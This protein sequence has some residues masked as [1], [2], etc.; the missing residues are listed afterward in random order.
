MAGV[1]AQDL[2]MVDVYSC[3]PV[4]VQIASRELK[5]DTTRP[6]TVTGGLTWAGGRQPK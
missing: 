3:F 4:A 5:L 2:D 6:L 1:E